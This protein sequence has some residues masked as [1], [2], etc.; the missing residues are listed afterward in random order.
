MLK[1]FRFDKAALQL[2]A[3]GAIDICKPLIATYGPVG[4]EVLIQM[5][6]QKL[7]LTKSGAAIIQNYSN[8]DLFLDQG[9]KLVQEAILNTAD[10]VGDGTTLTAILSKSMIEQAYV[11]LMAGYSFVDL[12]KELNRTKELALTILKEKKVISSDPKALQKMLFFH[13]GNESS[14]QALDEA[15]QAVGVEGMIQIEASK[16]VET[17]VEIVSGLSMKTSKILVESDSNKKKVIDFSNPLIFISKD[18]IESFSS[19]LPALEYAQQE[20][21]EILFLLENITGE[22][23][24]V[25]EVNIAN[26]RV[27]AMALKLEGMGKS[28]EDFLRDISVY[29]GGK[30][31]SKEAGY[32]YEHITKEQFPYLLGNAKKIKIEKNST[33]ILCNQSKQVEEY[34]TTLQQR[35]S[36]MQLNDYD[37]QRYQDRIRRLQGQSAVVYIGSDT[38]SKEQEEIRKVQSAL[39]NIRLAKKNGVIIGGGSALVYALLQMDEETSMGAQ[40]LL[41]ALKEPFKILC[42]SDGVNGELKILELMEKKYPFGYDINTH[43]FCNMEQASILDAYD[44]IEMAIKQSTSIVSEWM[45]SAVLMVSTALDREDIALMKEGVPVMR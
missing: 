41:K 15:I 34:C 26:K 44:V 38:K 27:Y 31:L 9:A 19:L 24:K 12:R 29:T 32:E 30:I 18:T 33:W 35:I 42:E 25:L 40:I 37:R 23:K 8:S 14:I 2:F 11:Y 10:H 36:S 17:H 22:A 7:L 20:G 16:K 13:Y 39:R 43:D 3:K 4:R 45:S 21:K 6:G 5:E 1:A 28:K